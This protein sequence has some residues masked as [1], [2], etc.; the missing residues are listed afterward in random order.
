MTAPAAPRIARKWRPP[1]ALVVAGM[2]SFA[3]LAP[4]AS[5]FFFRIYENQLVRQ[6]EA[7]LIAQSAALAVA[8]ARRIET[9]IAADVPLGAEVPPQPGPDEPLRPILPALDLA[10][11]DLAP[12]RPS[13]RV[14]ATQADP[15]F[16]ALGRTMTDDLIAT[17]RVTLAGFRLL[18]PFGVVIGGRDEIGLSLAHI[19]EVGGA[20]RG[21]FRSVIRMRVSSHEPPPITSLSRGT[22]V[23]IFTAMPIILRDRVAA[24]LYASRTPANVFKHLY[25]ERRKVALAAVTVVVL[26]ALVGFAFHRTLMAPVRRLI[27][28]TQRIADGDRSAI[29][30][31]SHHGTAE[32]A[33]LSQSFL[34]M[35]AS[36]AQSADFIET[37]AAHVSHE[38]KSPLTSIKG[39]AELL[40]DDALDPTMSVEERVRFL[41]QILDDT[42]RLSI[43]VTRL[44]ELAR[45]RSAPTLGETSLGKVLD[46]VRAAAPRLRIA[47]HGALDAQARMSGET[48][49]IALAHLADNAAAH[50]AKQMAI[51]ARTL[52]DQLEIVLRDDGPGVS[53]NNRGRIFEPFFTTRRA[54][55]GTGMGLAIVRAMLETHGGSIALLEEK[56][57]AFRITIPLARLEG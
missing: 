42:G 38:L 27:A 29:R 55:G 3:V 47:A 53:P 22:N 32:F 19:E 39:A 41:T 26:T 46:E 54:E 1:L 20:L 33:H 2:L 50:G 16:L 14:V 8:V 37:F 45:A 48:L 51:N 12:S 24:V 7:E 11:T 15:A 44:R 30:P 5:V 4:L 9:Q 17:Q 34:D 10:S 13:A 18:D 35:A 25:E 28:R 21:E 56:G 40:R 43:L 23:R 49:G 36:L 52:L 31:L 57:A 6:T